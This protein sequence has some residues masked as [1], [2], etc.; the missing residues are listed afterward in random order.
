MGGGERHNG[1][2][3][4]VLAADGAEVDILGHSDIDLA[5]VGRHLGLDL[6]GCRYVRIPDRGEEDLSVLST[7]YDLFVNGSYMSRIPTRSRRAAYLCFFPT[8][9]DHDMAAWRKAAVR[10]AGPLLRGV[11][12]AIDFGTGWFP[13]EGGKIRQ[14]RWSSSKAVLAISAGTQRTLRADFGRPG[15]PAGTSLRVVGPGGDTLAKIDVGAEFATHEIPLPDTEVGI[16]ITLLCDT[17]T[18]G[19]ADIRELGFAISRPRI[20]D[21][22]DS[23]LAKV[24]LRFPWLL[25][26]PHDLAWLDRYDVVMANSDYTRTWIRRMWRQEADILYPPIQVDRLHPAPVR[27]RTIVT[28]GRFFAPGLGHAKRQLEMVEWFGELH[29]AG[30]LPGWTLHV[31][32]GMEDSQKPYVKQ[33]KDAAHGLPVEVH[34]NAP[35]AD[36]EKLVST[37]SVFW[38]ATGWGEDERRRPWTAEHFGMTTV[39]A[40]AGGCVPVVI[41]R[42]GQREIVRHGIDGFRWT[43]PAQLMS[44]TRRLATEDDLRQRLA[45]EA[46]AQAQRFSDAAFAERWR[47]IAARHHLYEG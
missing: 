16:E 44:F 1:M 46:A 17:F 14:W 38:S 34:P 45:D 42:A 11:R 31:V 7:E 13:P 8:P 40:M 28:V 15:A 39:E 20:S 25:R 2:I 30:H 9:F 18:P 4:Q 22:A 37:A 33:V 24:A 3:A 21:V 5:E 10:S 36:V 27:E 19:P 32:G 26:D 43:E 23:P 41:D 12:P 6:S 29:E 47:A 35:R